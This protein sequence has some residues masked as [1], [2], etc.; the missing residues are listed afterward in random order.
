MPCHAVCRKKM[1]ILASESPRR[2]EL[3]KRIAPAFTII[4]AQVRELEEG[5][6]LAQLPEKNALLKA[7][8]VAEK[9]PQAFVIGA[10]TA[11]FA[12]GEMLGKPRSLE[13]GAAMLARLSGREH[14]VISGTALI[15]RSR[16]VCCH[17]ST[18]SRVRF[19]V[20]SSGEIANYMRHV[21]VLDKAG[22][23][24]IQEF[25]ELLGASWEGE[26]ENIIGLPMVTLTGLL[27]QYGLTRNES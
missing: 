17:W 22:A 18:V 10:D 6:D 8:A 25:P 14:Q 12:D 16:E 4:P 20:L 5:E 2:R 9:M 26:L 24:G 19:K 7:Q 3:L 27:E 21:N 15:C 1:L 13:E 23:Y 11:V